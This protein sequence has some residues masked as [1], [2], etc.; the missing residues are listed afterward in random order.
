MPMAYVCCHGEGSPCV[1]PSL[2][3]IV[4]TSI[5]REDLLCRCWLRHWR[6]LGKSVGHSPMWLCGLSCWRHSARQLTVLLQ[7]PLAHT[8]SRGHEWLP[9]NCISAQHTAGVSPLLLGYLHVC[10]MV[11]MYSP[12]TLLVTSPIP[13]GRSPGHL[14]VATNLLAVSGLNGS[15]STGEEQILLAVHANAAHSS[16]VALWN[17]QH[18]LLHRLASTPDGPAPPSVFRADLRMQRP[19]ISS[20]IMGWCGGALASPSCWR[21]AVGCRGR[22]TGCFSRKTSLTGFPSIIW[23]WGNIMAPLSVDRR[24]EAAF[25]LPFIASSTTFLAWTLDLLLIREEVNLCWIAISP[26]RRVRNLPSR[27]SFIGLS[28]RDMISAFGRF[29]RLLQHQG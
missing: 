4:S 26:S 8:C 19:L 6:M 23:S 15:G 21:R 22:A 13:I 12:I 2:E 16:D 17:E 24:R 27:H 10:M 3:K 20:N 11:R 25:T 29:K 28:I 14:S 5:Y 1:V 9:H 18:I 7:C